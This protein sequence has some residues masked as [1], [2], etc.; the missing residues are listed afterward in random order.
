[1]EKLYGEIFKHKT[2]RVLHIRDTPIKDISDNTFDSLKDS[3]EEL[4]LVNTW[5][6]RVPPSIKNLTSLKVRSLPTFFEND[7]KLS[8]K[9]YVLTFKLPILNIIY[10]HYVV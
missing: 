6:T 1:M 8:F 7:T 9:D 4:H 2:V 3:L 10:T 5:L